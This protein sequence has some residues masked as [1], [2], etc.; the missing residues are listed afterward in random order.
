MFFILSTTT[1]CL[2][3]FA[4]SFSKF[5]IIDGIE[6]I[7]SH[8]KEVDNVPLLVS[9]FTDATTTTIKEMVEIFR[10]N[11]EIVLCVGS[12]CRVHNSR[13]FHASDLSI[14]V[15]T[16]PG[17]KSQIPVNVSDLLKYLFSSNTKT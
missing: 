7:K 5:S 3:S 6:A 9:L 2:S 14:A 17:D 13:I 11:G 8:L 12:S 10:E 16:L 4:S 1:L 15:A